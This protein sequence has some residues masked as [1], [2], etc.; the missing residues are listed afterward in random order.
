SGEGGAVDGVDR[1]VALGPVAGAHHLAVEQHRSVVL[2]PLADHDRA[3]ERDRSEERAHGIHRGAVGRVLVAEPDEVGRTDG[4][5]LGRTHELEREVAVGHRGSQHEAHA[6]ALRERP[7]LCS[8]RSRSPASWR[9]T[10][11][12]NRSPNPSRNAAVSSASA[13]SARSSMR[14]SSCHCS[15]VTPASRYSIAPTAGTLPSGVSDAAASPAIRSMIQARTRPFS[16][17]P[18]HS[19][20]PSASLRNQLT[21]YTAGTPPVRR[22][23]WPTSSQ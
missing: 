15:S 13:S 18:G 22:R 17:N 16:L 12:G 2:L 6:T 4:G 10:A 8:S 21:W 20:E 14:N 5:G 1:D 3:A 11:S 23:R 7:A 9:R 19:Q